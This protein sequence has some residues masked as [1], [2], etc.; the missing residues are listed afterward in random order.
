[1]PAG[2][3]V[4]PLAGEVEIEP[5]VHLHRAAFGTTNMTVAWR[6]RILGAAQHAPDLDLVAVAPDG[7][8][9]AFC[10]GWLH[11]GVEGV[12]GQIEPLGV[13][14]EHQGRGLGRAL[15]FETL[16]RMMHQHG[17]DLA[18]IEVERDNTTARRLYERDGGFSPSYRALKYR[19][20]F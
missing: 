14:P 13:H 15:L 8:L 17:V 5:Y 12:E 4:R 20:R 1:V 2:Y 6:K 19:R 7:A 16:R 10:I 18:H 3:A 11:Q 9:A